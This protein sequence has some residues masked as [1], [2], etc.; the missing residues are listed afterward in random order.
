MNWRSGEYWCDRTYWQHCADAAAV[1]A[2]QPQ[3]AVGGPSGGLWLPGKRVHKTRVSHLEVLLVQ[4]KHQPGAQQMS[5]KWQ[6]FVRTYCGS[7]WGKRRKG[8]REL[9]GCAA[10][11]VL[12]VFY[13]GPPVSE[14]CVSLKWVEDG[15]KGGELRDRFC[16]RDRFCVRDQ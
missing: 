8:G 7:M 11:V 14:W 10:A 12:P 15:S 1:R 6:K 4:G 13:S 5:E 16:M 2:W 9:G 3:Q